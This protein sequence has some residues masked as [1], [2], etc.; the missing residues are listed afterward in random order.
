MSGAREHVR[1][2]VV[3]SDPTDPPALLGQW[4]TEVGVE[5]TEV[6]ADAGEPVPT[7]LPDDID[8]LVVLGGAMAAWEDDVAPWLPST[9]ALIA[10]TVAAGQPVLGVCLGGQLMTLALGGAVE[11]ALTPEVGVTELALLPAAS[12]RKSTRLNSSHRNTSRMP[13]SA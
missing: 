13:S 9:R 8:G 11:R 7:T 1:L 3:R 4:W 5:L 12:D 2:L 10:S 6:H